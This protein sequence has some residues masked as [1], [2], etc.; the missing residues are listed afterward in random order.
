MRLWSCFIALILV[1]LNAGC[2]GS[3]NTVTNVGLFGDWNVTMYP[4]GSTTPVYVFGLA[5]SQ[6]GSSNY[7]GGSIAY[8]GGVAV[9]SNMCINAN[10][11]SATA[12]TSGNNFT[13][14]V[15][16]STSETVITVHGTLATQNGSSLSGT[17]SNSASRTC[18]ASSGT[19]SMI[20]QQ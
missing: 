13:M 3:N 14:T 8:T 4:T 2:G 10:A 7:S 1:V 18:S 5:M 19:V 20:P 15:T 17:Y 12:T 9:P 16:D 11:L 6:E